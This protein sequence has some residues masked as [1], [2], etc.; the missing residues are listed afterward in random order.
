MRA[1]CAEIPY[2]SSRMK[3]LLAFALIIGDFAA[4]A[5]TYLTPSSS[6]DAALVANMSLDDSGIVTEMA[7]DEA[8]AAADT[9]T[10]TDLLLAD[11]VDKGDKK[12][13]QPAHEGRITR[14]A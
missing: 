6:R 11:W 9:K 1:C 2:S 8:P 4:A 5:P 12:R 7:P 14:A 10:W 13:A 3:T